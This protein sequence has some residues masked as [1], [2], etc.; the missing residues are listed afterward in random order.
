MRYRIASILA[1]EG[2]DTAGTK[3]IDI[4]DTKPMSRIT[5]QMK[6][7]NSTSVPTAHPAKMISKIELVDG[8]NVLFSLSGVEAQALNY[9]ERGRMPDGLMSYVNDTYCGACFELNFGR[10][11][12]DEMFAFDPTKFSNPQLKITHNK[13]SGGCAPDAGIL[14]V[15]AHCFDEQ[16]VKPIGFMMSKEQFSYTLT[17]SAKQQI[18]L[19]CDM[20]YRFLFIKSLASG[21]AP[22]T[23]FNKIK[24]SE[25]ND[26]RVIINDEAT[27]DLIK[28]LQDLPNIVESILCYDLDGE[29]TIYCTPSY[30]EHVV[31][32]GM[33]A[34]DTALF[35]DQGYGGTFD[36]TGTANQLSTFVVRG[37]LP[38]G[39]LAIPFGKKDIPED[40]Y[41]VSKV[42]TLKLT[43]T[44]GAGAGT[45][46]IFSQQKRLY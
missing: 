43:L 42:G 6:G 13:A 27:S 9:Y 36:A 2:A 3:T 16:E 30:L 5:I 33:N 46:E 11:L 22:Y 19:A 26:Q 24:L 37:L 40:W 45:I 1:P 17:A 38:H 25:N 15:F 4:T 29:E 21:Y 28:L 32:L 7:M 10:Y 14:S 31:G 41:D 23:Q 12:H 34:A 39:T 20:P 18:D 44:A 8:S 35:A